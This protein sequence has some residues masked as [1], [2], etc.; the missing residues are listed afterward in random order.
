LVI[1]G[2]LTANYTINRKVDAKTWLW[3]SL[4]V[5]SA[6]AIVVEIHQIGFDQFVIFM[7]STKTYRAQNSPIYFAFGILGFLFFWSASWL[8]IRNLGHKARKWVSYYGGNTFI[9]FLYGNILLLFVPKVNPEGLAYPVTLVVCLLLSLACVNLYYWS[10]KNLKLVIIYNHFIRQLPSRF[11][12]VVIGSPRF[13]PQT[14]QPEFTNQKGK[15]T[16]ALKL[17]SKDKSPIDL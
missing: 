5:L 17:K 4:V 15:T 7:A 3:V 6:G 14:P 10:S 2:E 9:I 1:F 11:F 12:G 13:K 8:V 16:P